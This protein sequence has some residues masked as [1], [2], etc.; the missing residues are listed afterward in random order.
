[1]FV[2]TPPDK[3]VASLRVDVPGC[4]RPTFCSS[5]CMITV[6]EYNDTALFLGINLHFLG[7]KVHVDNAANATPTL[8]IPG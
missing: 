2:F 1:M 5:I 7:L 4:N 3:A 6:R 8:N